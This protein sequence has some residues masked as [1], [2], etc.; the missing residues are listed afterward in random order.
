MKK[1]LVTGGTTFVS[2][3][4]ATYYVNK[5]F[6]VY[7][8][9]RGTKEQVTGT[10]LI[11]TDRHEIGP[12]VFANIHFDAILDITAYNKS[13]IADLLCAKPDFDVYIMIS[14]SAVY[15]E[16]NPRPFA[17]EQVLGENKFWGK[18]GTDKIEAEKELLSH[19]PG[20]Y[21]LRPPYLYGEM[22]NIYREAFV[23]SCAMQDREFYLPGDGNMGLQFFHV[24]DLCRFMDTLMEQRPKQQIYNVGNK[25]MVSIRDWVTLC[26][27]AVGKKPVFVSVDES[28]EQRDYFSF[29]NYEYELDVQKQY[30]LMESTLPLFEG[31][32]R[33]F[34]WYQKNQEEVRVKPYFA[35]IEKNLK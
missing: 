29:Y 23:F 19:V 8:L 22:N 17:E 10:K 31:L 16:Y 30:C 7:V 26:Y 34:E 33:S 1:I 3:Y 20:A 27:E 9:N 21:I 24:E 25:E 13:D 6:E 12:D 4:V 28:H 5:G 35:Y 15:P 18:Y 11:Q 14:S 2:K 32:K